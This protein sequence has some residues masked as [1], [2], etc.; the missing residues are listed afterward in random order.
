MVNRKIS[1]FWGAFV[2]V[3][4]LVFIAF[5]YLQ[6]IESIEAQSSTPTNYLSGYAWSSNIGWIAFGS[7]PGRVIVG[8]PNPTVNNRK[9]SGYAWSSNI[10]WVR[11]DPPADPSLPSGYP[12]L[13][14]PGVKLDNTNKNFMFKN[15]WMDNNKIQISCHF[16][17]NHRIRQTALDRGIVV[18]IHLS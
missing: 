1:L 17:I 15:N 14:F 3:A 18:S 2:G 8:Q 12:S 11:F 4:L 5:L 13:P 10:G 9:L 7:W 6:P 16:Q